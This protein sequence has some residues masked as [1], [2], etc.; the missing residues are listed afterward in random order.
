MPNEILASVS[1]VFAA[2]A[3]KNFD[4]ASL[5]PDEKPLGKTRPLLL[6]K[7][8]AG[9]G[10]EPPDDSLG[11]VQ[12]TQLESSLLFGTRHVEHVHLSPLA[13]TNDARELVVEAGAVVTVEGAGALLLSLGVVQHAHTDASFEFGARHVEQFHFAL[14]LNISLNG[15]SGSVA[16]LFGVGGVSIITGR[17]S[18]SFVII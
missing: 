8:S 11:V 17:D 16:A 4:A 1:A 18:F 15:F 3:A 14:L 7:G 9:F 2:G 13:P 12:H 6:A 10:A 5:A